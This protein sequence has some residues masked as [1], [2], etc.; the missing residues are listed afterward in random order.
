MLGAL[1][2]R[3]DCR[4]PR[5]CWEWCARTARRVVRRAGL[6]AREKLVPL[7]W[8]EPALRRQLLGATREKE[9]RG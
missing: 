7:R 5:E 9:R 6:G 2:V 3:W 8:A 4:A 1:R